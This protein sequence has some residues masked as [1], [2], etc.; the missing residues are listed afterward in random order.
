MVQ[1]RA[2]L[3][4]LQRGDPAARARD[5]DHLAD[6]LVGV[7][8]MLEHGRCPAGPEA[9]VVVRQV[10]RVA[11]VE[12]NVEVEATGAAARL[13]GHRFAN[14]DPG[15]PAILRQPFGY[16]YQVGAGA[17]ADIEHTP[18]VP[19]A[20]LIQQDLLC[21]TEPGQGVGGVEE[22]DQA[23][24]IPDRVDVTE[25]RYVRGVFVDWHVIPFSWYG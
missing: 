25:A 12:G 3:V 11:G 19:E 2:A 20:Q 23:L 4:E 9:G 22:G 24:G 10:R 7:G 16:R 14:V 18:C 8:D 21:C 17:A 13:C 15:R 6:H 1:H 5:A